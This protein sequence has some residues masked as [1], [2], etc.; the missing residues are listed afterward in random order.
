[1]P[2]GHENNVIQTHMRSYKDSLNV[3]DISYILP[4]N[5]ILDGLH[6]VTTETCQNEIEK[7]NSRT[8]G[9]RTII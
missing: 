1:M 3:S 2:A 6:F 7:I 4:S 9:Y 5:E 8:K